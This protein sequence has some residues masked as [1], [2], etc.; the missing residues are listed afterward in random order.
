MNTPPLDPTHPRWIDG[1]RA[2][3][4]LLDLG[5][6]DVA[7][8]SDLIRAA[9]LKASLAVQRGDDHQFLKAHGFATVL[10]ERREEM[11]A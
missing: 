3:N 4:V 2:A 7:M 9:E 11:A 6:L 8:S 1:E 10:R 5:V